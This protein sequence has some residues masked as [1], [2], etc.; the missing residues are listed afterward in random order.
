MKKTALALVLS[1]VFAFSAQAA[2][3]RSISY[4]TSWGVG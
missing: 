2:E 3:N 4:L 1:S